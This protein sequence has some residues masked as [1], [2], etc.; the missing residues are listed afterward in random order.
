[1]AVENYF[2]SRE[3]RILTNKILKFMR[4]LIIKIN[5]EA[6]SEETK[7]TYLAWK[8]Y[9]YAYE[10]TDDVYAYDYTRVD[11]I[12]SGMPN[13]YI[14]EHRI[15]DKDKAYALQLKNDHFV[16][17]LLSYLR[18]ERINN[19]KEKNTYYAQFIGKPRSGQE[20]RIGNRDKNDPSDPDFLNI[21]DIN[22]HDY[23]YTY[24][25]VFV[26]GLI[27]EIIEKHPSYY[28]LRF[29]E[30]PMS[31]YQVRKM[32]QFDILYSD[33]SL[34]RDYELN[35]FYKIYNQK[36]IYM[37]ELM[38]IEG[39][40]SRFDMYPFMMELLLLQDVFMSFFNSYM[41]N[42]ALANY[43]DQE[44]FDILDSYNLSSL[45]KVRISTLRKIIRD[46]PDLMELRG[47]D[48]I[49]EKLLDIVADDSVT[50]K[51]YYLSKIYPIGSTGQIDIDTTKTYEDN[52]D[53][54]FKEKIIRE[55]KTKLDESTVKYD[56][57]SGDD[58]TWGGE[59][60]G[61]SDDE[62]MKIKKQFKRELLQMDF[63][64]IL[65]KYLTISSTVNSYTKQ[66]DMQNMLGLLWQYLNKNEQN[67]FL[68]NEEIEF[69]S[70]KI[71]GLELYAAI[72]WFHQYFSG[73]SEPEVINIR[74]M[75]ISNIIALRD[76][77]VRDLVENLVGDDENSG[78]KVT[79]PVGLGDKKLTDILGEHD[80]TDQNDNT[81]D[82]DW[83]YY[84]TEDG[85]KVINYNN[86]FVNFEG[87]TTISEIFAD[88]SKNASIINALKTRWLKSSTL[89]EAK[90]WDYLIQQNMTNTYFQILFNNEKR[91]DTYIKRESKE[92]CNY[93]N[94]VLNSYPYADIF[95]VYVKLLETFRD[96]IL[97]E[98][99]NKLSLSTPNSDED[100]SSVDYLE[101]LKLLFNEFLSIYTEL[102]KIEY[103]QVLDDSPY[104]RIK[105]LYYYDKDVIFNDFESKVRLSDKLSNETME[106]KE[107]LDLLADNQ[108]TS[109]NSRI[110]A[111]KDYMTNFETIKDNEKFISKSMEKNLLSYMREEKTKLENFKKISIGGLSNEQTSF[112]NVYERLIKL[113][114]N[115]NQHLYD[116]IITI[117]DGAVNGKNVLMNFS[118]NEINIL[119]SE[120]EEVNKRKDIL[121]KFRTYVEFYLYE[122]FADYIRLYYK[123]IS[124]VVELEY[125]S[126]IYLENKVSQLKEYLEY[127]YKDKISLAHF[128]EESSI[129]YTIFADQFI[130]IM[131]YNIAIDEVG[132][133]RNLPLKIMMKSISDMVYSSK[134]ESL[135]LTD[136]IV[137]QNV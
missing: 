6:E 84:K 56:E 105:L 94:L 116:E 1:M 67:N 39:F 54:V 117:Y 136:V 11:C 134:K 71:K 111:I 132:L 25:Y 90:C 124:D 82:D 26:G 5:P 16:I 17:Q 19:Y 92:F 33:T 80:D 129:S 10:G 49:I 29:L 8:R 95:A 135:K 96:F 133:L 9:Q 57:F 93:L 27:N 30:N 73:V 48:L 103:S 2:L 61:L 36:K 108:L 3:G 123:S 130:K 128:V 85:K 122:A 89:Q 4:S 72:C 120:I 79:L 52:I 78:T 13:D 14:N 35:N 115:D 50:I 51:R 99:E 98:T 125:N 81:S 53:I 66:V 7:E 74:N 91:F 64:N 43:S 37:Q 45:K 68:I 21:E 15:L 104:N 22:L 83:P 107:V 12:N 24:E 101:D 100:D 58:D 88:Y 118:K 102:H 40:N 126:K 75:N 109:K 32:E 69:E 65:T 97:D 137:E 18:K 38:Y 110:N 63:S 62:K 70:Y 127:Y 55:G 77:G 114:D 47:S 112:Y 20:I 113:L 60:E 46:I 34:L 121:P 23:P 41:D 28:Y 86:V 131:K 59:L 119:E 42:F 106:Y 87:D 31:I 76:V 44:I